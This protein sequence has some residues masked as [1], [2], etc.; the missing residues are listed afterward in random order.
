MKKDFDVL[1]IELSDKE[2]DTWIQ[3]LNEL[4]KSREHSHLQYKS[5][6]VLVHHKE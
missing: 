6:Q 4:K 3:R 5:G 1:E 2:I